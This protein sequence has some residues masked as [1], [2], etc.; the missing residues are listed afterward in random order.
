MRSRYEFTEVD[1][2]TNVSLGLSRVVFHYTEPSVLEGAECILKMLKFD[3]VV[4]TLHTL[5]AGAYVYFLSYEKTI[6][7]QHITQGGCQDPSWQLDVLTYL[8]AFKMGRIYVEYV[9]LRKW[10]KGM[11]LTSPDGVTILEY[12]VNSNIML[13]VCTSY[14]LA[15]CYWCCPINDLFVRMQ[16]VDIASFNHRTVTVTSCY[17]AKFQFGCWIPAT[18]NYRLEP[19]SGHEQYSRTLIARIEKVLVKPKWPTLCSRHFLTDF[20]VWFFCIIENLSDVLGVQFLIKH[21]CFRDYGIVPKWQQTIFCT[22][23]IMF[24]GVDVYYFTSMSYH[25]LHYC[26]RVLFPLLWSVSYHLC[27]KTTILYRLVCFR[28]FNTILVP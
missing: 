7:S 27:C 9:Y 13:W 17:N 14:L 19:H 8:V 3:H 28:V 25:F 4:W 20:R 24:S 2:S 15:I 16:S 5:T 10:S 6:K 11:T 22:N 26:C 12:Y 18:N 21:R 1:H 23:Y